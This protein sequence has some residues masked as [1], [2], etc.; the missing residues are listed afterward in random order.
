MIQVPYSCTQVLRMYW[1]DAYEDPYVQP[2]TVYLFGKV[3]IETA[4]SYVSCCL[5]VKNI[6]RHVYVLPRDTVILFLLQFS[7]IEN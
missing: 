5:T 7:K 3:Y 4:K 6:E 2:G 1:L